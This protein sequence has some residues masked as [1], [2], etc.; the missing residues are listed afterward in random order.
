MRIPI[1]D[2]MMALVRKP[3]GKARRAAVS[4]EERLLGALLKAPVGIAFATTDGHWL[5][6]N[7]RFLELVGYARNEL[8]RISFNGLTH[9]EDA[10]KEL[11]LMKRL[12]GG[13][14]DSYRIEKRLMGKNGRYLTVPVLTAIARTEDL[15]IHVID[16]PRPPTAED[17][18]DAAVI[19]VDVRGVV[20]GWNA[21]AER[22]LGYKRDE[23]IGLNRRILYRDADNWSGR[24]TGVLREAYGRRVE[25]EDW[26]VTKD[27]RTSGCTRP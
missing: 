4:R 6:V 3:A 8:A 16:E 2:Q 7:D 26:R 25:M 15:L 24:S 10:A 21:A 18:I 27:A 14:V 23:I 11:V 17:L 19:H 22:M 20:I 9:S 12:L 1:V 13:D 5:L